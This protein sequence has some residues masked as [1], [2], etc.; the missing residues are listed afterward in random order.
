[1][2]SARKQLMLDD[3]NVYEMIDEIHGLFMTALSSLPAKI[4]GR[5][6]G[7]R[8]KVEKAIYDMR[9]EL[10]AAALARANER[11]EPPEP[12]EVRPT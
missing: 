3:Q 5:D 1:M 2:P 12:P 7:E 6:L 11:G 8:R 10:S 9:V 4:G